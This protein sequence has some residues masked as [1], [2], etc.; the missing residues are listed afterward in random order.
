[1]E[2]NFKYIEPKI[3]D[4][5]ICIDDDSQD[6]DFGMSGI[7]LKGTVGLVVGEEY[8]IETLDF[9]Q[10]PKNEKGCWTEE[11]YEWIKWYWIR[12][13]ISGKGFHQSMFLGCFKPKS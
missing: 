13:W 1:M 12:A 7:V 8:T 2:K 3:G 10:V 5:I 6:E 4:K 11:Q 9:S